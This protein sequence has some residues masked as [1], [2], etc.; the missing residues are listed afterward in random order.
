MMK[1]IN[2]HRK[3]KLFFLKLARARASVSEISYG[4]AIGTFISVFPTFGFGMPLVIILS[5]FFKF[6]LLAALALSAI[7]NPFTSPF[8]L[9]LSYKIGVLFTGNEI[10]F[11]VQNWQQNLSNTGIT[12]LIG[13]LMLSGSLSVM[14]YFITKTAV[15]SYRKK[16][17]SRHLIPFL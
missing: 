16:F 15:S 13:N 2:I 5:R 6:N 8:F 1:K 4:A 17:R 11:T 7:S 9:V 14:A 10:A 12:L 3:L